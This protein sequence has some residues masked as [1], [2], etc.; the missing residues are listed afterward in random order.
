MRRF[1]NYL[2]F[3]EIKAVLEGRGFRPKLLV[4]AD[5][6]VGRSQAVIGLSPFPLSNAEHLE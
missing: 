4:T 2:H 6:C 3:I 1:N 5:G